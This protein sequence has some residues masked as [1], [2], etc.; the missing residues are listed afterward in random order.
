MAN[1]KFSEEAEWFLRSLQRLQDDFAESVGGQIVTTDKEGNLITKMSGA[2]RVCQIIMATE[3]GKKK[4]GEAYK[5]AL[6]LVRTQKAPVFMDCYAGFSS[7]WVPII[8]KGEIVG[9]ITG[10]GGRYDRGE[11]R[12]ELIEKYSKLAD[13][14]RIKDKKDFLK[15]AIDE[16]K[17][18]TE[19]EMKKRAQR[20]SKLV[21]ILA[22]ETDLGEVF[23]VY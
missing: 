6:S 15:A 4:C 10:C 22:E 9:S 2:Q 13:E 18:V 1:K 23:G 12:E 16:I 5:C 20:L 11:T 21:G 3:E 14:L 19:E 7:L 17:P 8:V